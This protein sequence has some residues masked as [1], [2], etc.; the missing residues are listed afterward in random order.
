MAKS[1]KIGNIVLVKVND[2]G[3]EKVARVVSVSH[4]NETA[5][6]MFL[7]DLFCDTYLDSV[8]LLNC[9]LYENRKV[10]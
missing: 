3:E 9:R 1:I 4:Q 5:M 10:I 7:D 6:V 2:D 8:P